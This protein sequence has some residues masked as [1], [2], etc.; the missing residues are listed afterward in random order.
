MALSLDYQLEYNGLVFGS[1]TSF[2][3]VQANGLDDLP[4]VRVSDTP[5][6]SDHG[7]FP[8]N[9]YAGGRVVEVELE[10]TGASDAAFRANV[11]ALGAATILRQTELPLSF[12]LP[13]T[14]NGRRIY[15]RPRRRTLPVD[16][17]YLFH[18]GKAVIQFVATDPRVYADTETVLNTAA[19]TS[20]GGRT[21]NRTY[22]LVY[23][24]G[25]SGGTLLA[26]NS[27]N[28]PTRP[29]LTISGPCNTPRIENVT[30]GEFI[31]CNLT[32]ASGDMLVIDMGA[33]TVLLNGTASRYS[34]LV[35]GSTFWDLEPGANSLKFTSA[36]SMGTLQV[37]F[38]SAWL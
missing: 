38:R 25:G 6:P 3:L 19:A 33:H 37:A 28:F 26:N 5:R 32:V 14:G 15:A 20:G 27:G 16:R 9:D 8:G 35:G 22:A 11:D 24:A 17:G 31:A 4:D 34:T 7:L 10:V 29:A 18:F 13:G 2:E 21:Y 30:T 12:R 23:A 36:D 1:G